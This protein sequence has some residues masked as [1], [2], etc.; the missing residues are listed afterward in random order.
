MSKN[1][2]AVNSCIIPIQSH[3]FDMIP[4]KTNCA[5]RGTKK[6]AVT[7]VFVVSPIFKRVSYSFSFETSYGIGALNSN[8]PASNSDVSTPFGVRKYF[9]SRM[10]CM[11][12]GESPYEMSS[13]RW[14]C[15]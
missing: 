7:T 9:L 6:L 11:I 12:S 10:I 15:S 3:S 5:P 1:E 2:R 8:R 13:G 14:N 4:F